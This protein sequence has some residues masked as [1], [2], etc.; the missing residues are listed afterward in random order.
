MLL[1]NLVGLVAVKAL[2]GL[3]IMIS[4]TACSY[5]HGTVATA[6]RAFGR[7]RPSDNK[8]CCQG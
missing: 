2:T 5:F 7:N 1:A 3:S 4:R 6:V 8:N